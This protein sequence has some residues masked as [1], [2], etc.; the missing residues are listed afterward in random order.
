MVLV[1]WIMKK[2]ILLVDDL[3]FDILLTRRALLAVGIDACVVATC[4]VEEAYR[5]LSRDRFDVV[6]LDIKMPC[7]DGFDFLERFHRQAVS[8]PVIVVTASLLLVDRSRA[9]ALG[10]HDYVIKAMEFSTFQA[11]LKAALSRLNFC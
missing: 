11:D 10:A 6:L 4:D 9:E 3:V 7:V 5:L 8:I 1:A 2:R